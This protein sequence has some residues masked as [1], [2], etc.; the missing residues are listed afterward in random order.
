MI[1]P[2]GGVVRFGLE[3]DDLAQ[4]T[5]ILHAAPL[6][7]GAALLSFDPGTEFAL[8]DW[9]VA[10][11]AAISVWRLD[12]PKVIAAYGSVYDQLYGGNYQG[13][14]DELLDSIEKASDGPRAAV[15]S[16]LL[17][18]LRPPLYR[19]R[20]YLGEKTKA[21]P[22][23][24]RTLLAAR[25]GDPR[26]AT[27]A[28]ERFFTGD[29]E[30]SIVHS[31]NGV[32]WQAKAPGAPL[33]KS[34]AD[35]PLSLDIA[36]IAVT[37][38]TLVVASDVDFLLGA[39]GTVEHGAAASRGLLGSKYFSAAS[40]APSDLRSWRDLAADMES[41]FRA[42]REHR[43]AASGDWESLLI[44]GLFLGDRAGD[45]PGPSVNA[46]SLP[47]FS[48]ISSFWGREWLDVRPAP[49]GW[50]AQGRISR[51]ASEE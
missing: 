5:R 9:L 29:D 48:R 37:R 20:D 44:E 8:P 24:Q 51:E 2:L 18:R 23:G 17:E 46:E 10:R 15:R 45:F 50:T 1:A 47:P 4:T 22:D 14:F 32:L 33:M 12:T 19:M 34:D 35:D 36:A 26:A 28:L 43:L 3:H 41:H 39:I 11:P 6:A 38:E 49:S 16:D 7:K 31:P 27:A 13:A 21:N 25:L 42:A 40:G 30:T